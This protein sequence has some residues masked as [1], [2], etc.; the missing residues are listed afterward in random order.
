MFKRRSIYSSGRRSSGVS[1]FALLMF[2]C[3]VGAGVWFFIR[4]LTSPEVTLDPPYSGRMGITQQVTINASDKSGIQS[5]SVTV[6][7]GSQSMVLV[8]EKYAELQKKRQ[9]AFTL[10]DTKLPAGDFELEIRVQDGSFAGF[11]FGNT[12]TM[13]MNVTLDAEPPRIA[14]RTVPPSV[15]RGGSALIAYTVSEEVDKTGVQLGKHFSPAYRQPNGGYACLFPFPITYKAA[16]YYPEIMARD[17]AGNVTSSRLPVRAVERRFRADTLSIPESFLNFKAAELARICP[18]KST[19]LE[20][21]LCANSKER[22]ADDAKLIEFGTDSSRISPT[23][24]WSGRFLRLPR[25]AER[26]RFGDF[27]TYVD[28]SRQKIDEQTHMG[29]DLAS[30]AR[31]EVPAAQ[32]G[33]VAWVG[34][35]GIH[36][37]MVLVDHGMGLMSQYSHLSDFLVRAGEDVQ[38]GQIIGH[39]G[40]TG[41]AG[42]DHLHFGILIFGIPVEPLEWLDEKWVRNN[43]T[44]RLNTPL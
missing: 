43:I 16:D 34:Y 27:R 8:R 29:V 3:V 26:A 23:F 28:G 39:T 30:V 40:T 10:K 5:I 41:L 1:A 20:Q 38:A 24:L 22:M 14:V 15:R 17:L 7:R 11:G 33:R 35:L 9:V 44:S 25:A 37:N 42:G 6:R 36:G 19:P 12:K 31:A 32:T 2:L 13:R 21:Y 18:E 4:D